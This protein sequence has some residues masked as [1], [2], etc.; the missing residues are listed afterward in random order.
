[1]NQR[2]ASSSVITGLGLCKT[3]PADEPP[4]R[5]WCRFIFDPFTWPVVMLFLWTKHLLNYRVDVSSRDVMGN[6]PLHLL[7]MRSRIPDVNHIRLLI[8]Y[9]AD[10]NTQNIKG[11]TPLFFLIFG[12]K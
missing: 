6:T 4:T 7:F 5:N 12:G 2:K 9:G 1:M 3:V 11:W 10:L 8:E